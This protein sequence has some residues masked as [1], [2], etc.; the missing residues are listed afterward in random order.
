M[1][2]SETDI[3]IHYRNTTHCLYQIQRF[4]IQSPQLLTPI[5]RENSLKS[6]SYSNAI[7]SKTNEDQT[8]ISKTSELTDFN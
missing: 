8:A 4:S 1:E 7:P 2:P 5:Q 3:P 6:L